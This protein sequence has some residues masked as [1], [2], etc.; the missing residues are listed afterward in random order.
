[1][2]NYPAACLIMFNPTILHNTDKEDRQL[3]LLISGCGQ[4]DQCSCSKSNCTEKDHLH[5]GAPE[6]LKH[7]LSLGKVLLTCI[8]KY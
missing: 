4:R 2:N 5:F 6:L 1:M 7:S 3:H 8:N